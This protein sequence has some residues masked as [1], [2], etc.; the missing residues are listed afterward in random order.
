MNGQIQNYAHLIE[1]DEE[2]RRITIFRIDSNGHKQLYT[3]MDL[4]AKKYD[5]D[6]KGF[7]EFARMLG[8]NI[9]F[10]SPTARK[11]LDI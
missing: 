1:M 7:K 8:E 2:K 4:P 5:E 9:L 3:S 11:I 10:D 6:E